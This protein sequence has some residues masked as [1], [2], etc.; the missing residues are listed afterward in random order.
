MMRAGYHI[1]ALLRFARPER[2]EVAYGQLLVTE[3][4]VGTY[5]L[6]PRTWRA[7]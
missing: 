2:A 1:E 7:E 6:R 4:T 3:A 5:Y